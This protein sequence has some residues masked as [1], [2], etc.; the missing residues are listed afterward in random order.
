MN[1]AW[2]SDLG[3]TLI[4]FLWQGAVV[5]GIYSIARIFARKPQTRYLIGCAALSLFMLTPVATFIRISTPVAAP[6]LRHTAPAVHS[7][8]STA[9]AVPA[10]SSPS[11]PVTVMPSIVML[12]FAGAGVLF[13]RLLFESLVACRLKS[14]LAYPISP[15][16]HDRFHELAARI[17]ISRRID[18][19]ASARAQ[20]PCVV[21]WLRPVILLPIGMLAGIP[22][23]QVEALLA[24]ELAHVLRHDYLVNLFQRLAEAILFY[25]PAVWWV[26]SEI[27]R[28][29]EHCCDDIAVSATG[30]AI[31]YAEALADLEASRATWPQ[32]ALAATDG[33]LPDR[34]A[35]LLGIARPR[36]TTAE[37]RAVGLAAALVLAIG[38]ALLAQS[39]GPKPAFEAA[40]ITLSPP[41]YFGGAQSYAKGDHYT[42][43]TATV[44]DLV[45]FAYGVLNF[46]ISGGPGWASTTHYNISAKMDASATPDQLRPMLQA[47]LADR[48]GLRFHRVTRNRSGYALT[49]DKNGPKLTESKNPGPGL[50][51]GRGHLN[52][53][54]A[55]MR[56][57]AGEL[58]SQLETPIANRTK[59]TA[60]YDFTL[61]WTPDTQIDDGSAPSLATALREQ[62][63]LRLD[64]VK[65]V[66][67]EFFVI[68]QVEQPSAN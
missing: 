45:A 63:G 59:L 38:A 48:F 29:R 66:P 43:L 14:P 7:E 1:A 50:G 16:W 30:D 13:L 17:G 5:A 3:W 6:T 65:N 33:S 52:G 39:A 64:P 26:S 2:V 68:D 49:L 24:H 42:A 19:L 61:T 57:L 41:E 27:R 60:L 67:V 12:W 53:R 35:R 34:I 25:H 20:V 31:L 58:S 40:S 36:E 37:L 23:D 21:G 44:R 55:N 10:S 15:E 18:L 32:T 4:H 54:G 46:Q 11:L 51:L 22:A 8:W 62:L 56:L 28:E 9:P 47:L